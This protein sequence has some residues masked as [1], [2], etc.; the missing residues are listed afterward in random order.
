MRH[1]IASTTNAT[2]PTNAGTKH[3]L[4]EHDSRRDVEAAVT[5]WL[6]EEHWSGRQSEWSKY[7][8]VCRQVH[9]LSEVRRV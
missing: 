1:S 5:R 7:G 9:S 6:L 8:A 4:P 3:D 2:D